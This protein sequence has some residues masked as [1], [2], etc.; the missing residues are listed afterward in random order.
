MGSVQDW[1]GISSM[2]PV[3]D[4]YY[5]SLGSKG[6]LHWISVGPVLDLFGLSKGSVLDQ[7]EVRIGLL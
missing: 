5:V 1:L 4:Q 6:D 7:S 3:S 2:G